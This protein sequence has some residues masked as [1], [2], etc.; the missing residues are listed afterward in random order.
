MKISQITN[1]LESL[2][3]LSSQ[4]GYDNSG[5]IVGSKDDEVS[6]VLIALD[7]TEEIIEE[8]KRKNCQMII[9][10][11]PI[12]FKGLKKLNGS[13]YVERTVIRAIQS[14]IAIYA[15]HT[16]LDNYR[17]GVNKE[18][19]N[20]LGLS[21][22][23]VLAPKNGT[24]DKV[25]VFVPREHTNTVAQ[26][27]FDAGGG[28]IG[29]YDECSFTINGEGTFRPLEGSDP[30]S[31]EQGKR[32]KDSED[33]LEMVVSSHLTNKVC[34]AMISAHPYEEV[35]HDIVALKNTNQYEGAGMIGELESPMEETAFLQKLKDTFG[36]GA[37]RHTDLLNK[38]VKKV[39]WCGGSGSFLLKNAISFEADFY[40][41]GDFKY[42]EFFDAEDRIVIADIGHY[43]SEQYTSQLLQGL[44]TEKFPKFAVH[45]TKVNTNPINYF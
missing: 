24:L 21:N 9:A 13:N 45:L 25:T 8:A 28:R 2:A 20:R 35:A 23:K 33:R 30:W 16:N 29:D 6:S 5:L 27:M 15:I 11:H 38:P 22:L 17:F 1:Y 40:I 41:T 26:A 31:G 7:C 18:I 19:G 43:E 36:V 34:R 37:I 4:E 44:L 39:A 3:P 12:V 10:H 14:N 42:H 32:S